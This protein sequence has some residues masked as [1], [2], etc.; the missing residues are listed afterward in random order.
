MS[1]AVLDDDRTGATEAQLTPDAGASPRRAAMDK[2]IPIPTILSVVAISISFGACAWVTFY[3]PGISNYDF[4]TPEKSLFSGL[5]IG[6]NNDFRA[7][8]ELMRV[9]SFGRE[10]KEKLKTIKVHREAE[11]HGK[12]IL[13][14][15]YEKNGITEYETR[16]FEK[17]AETGLWTSAF[18]HAFVVT[19]DNK[20]WAAR[21]TDWE[22]KGKR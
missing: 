22:N 17:D 10:M 13:F 18:A 21:M 6:A 9:G 4:S 7:Q 15:S 19:D 16:A 11:W 14:I 2:V 1:Q 3:H 20:T 8:A 12:K 5:E